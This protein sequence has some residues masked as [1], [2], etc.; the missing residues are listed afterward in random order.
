[1]STQGHFWQSHL[2]DFRFFPFCPFFFP[3]FDHLLIDLLMGLFRGAVFRCGA[4]LPLENPLENSPLRKGA[5]RGSWSACSVLSVF[6]AVF[7]LFFLGFAACPGLIRMFRIVS[8]YI[9]IYGLNMKKT[10]MAGFVRDGFGRSPHV[11]PSSCPGRLYPERILA[12]PSS[13]KVVNFLWFVPCLFFQGQWPQ[14]PRKRS[15][16]SMTDLI[17]A[18]PLQNGIQ[19]APKIDK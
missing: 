1:M 7:L 10:G 19:M 12:K 4:V 13:L 17:T 16:K 2:P 15:T 6:S 8:L 9:Y 18:A 5:L 14:N 11:N 3:F